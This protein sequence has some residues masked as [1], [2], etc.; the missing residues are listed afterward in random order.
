MNGH[1]NK[2]ET[3]N[4]YD[5]GALGQLGTKSRREIAAWSTIVS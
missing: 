3:N 5:L 2:A 1:R 4:A